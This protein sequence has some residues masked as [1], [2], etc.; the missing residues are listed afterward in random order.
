MHARPEFR[1]PVREIAF[2]SNME[3][4]WLGRVCTDAELRNGSGHFCSFGDV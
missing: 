1:K 4:E 2:A 3:C